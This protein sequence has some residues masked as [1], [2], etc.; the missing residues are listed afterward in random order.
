MTSRRDLLKTAAVSTGLLALGAT[1]QALAAPTQAV[2]ASSTLIGAS[3]S[4]GAHQL[5]KLPYVYDALEPF[6]DAKT[7]EIHHT[8]HHQGYVNG[9]NSTEQALMEARAKGDMG[10]IPNLEK[11]LA[12]HGSGHVNHSIYWQN[13]KPKGK[14]KALPGGKLLNQINKDF[15]TYEAF[16]AQF[17]QAAL[18]AEGSGWAGLFWHPMFQRLYIVTLLNHQNS[19]LVGGVPVLL[20]DVWEHAYYVKYQNMRLDYIKAWWNV[21]DWAD[22]E[23]RFAAATRLG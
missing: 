2:S 21:V 13:M 6:I 7:L 19:M 16:K 20:C 10:A 5:P 18:K 11:A 14:A 4:A 17:D 12:F 3:P 8:K 22:V 23:G 1:G 15:G 9:L